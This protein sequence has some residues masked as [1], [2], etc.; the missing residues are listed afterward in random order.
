MQQSPLEQHLHERLDAADRHELGHEVAAA[1]AQVG[2]HR[3]AP[4][5]AR[6]VI[7][8]QAHAGG[9][10]DREQV[11]HGVGG[12]PERDDHGDGIFERRR[13]RMSRG[14]EALAHQAHHGLAGAPAVGA[15]V[16]PDRL[17]RGAAG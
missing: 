17:L 11:Q 3:H 1:G 13:V 16:L 2:E 5:D 6:E 7:K 4:A 8:R 10:R 12:A 15:L 14:F 9:V